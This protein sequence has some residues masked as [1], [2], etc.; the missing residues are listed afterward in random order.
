ME[1]KGLKMAL[2]KS[3]AETPIAHAAPAAAG[4]KSIW[5]DLENSPHVPFFHP[6]IGELQKD[7]RIIVTA[8]DCFQVCG[9][10]DLF[11]M[12][13]LRIGRHYGKHFLNK[14]AGLLIR[15]LQILPVA[16][17]E[18]PDL[19]V[20]HGSRSQLLVCS[21]LNIP[22]LLI[23]DYEHAIKLVNPTWLMMPEVIPA[24]SVHFDA[25][26]IIHYPGIKEDVYVPSF[27][28]DPAIM[29]ELKLSPESLIVTVRPPATEAHY[30]NPDGEKLFVDVINFLAPAKAV[31]V[32]LPRNDRQ[33][34]FVNRTWPELCARG[35]VRIPDHVVDGL[36]LIW[37]S[38]LVISGGGTINREAAA[39]GV[40]VYSIFRGRLGALDRYL[41]ETGRLVLI[42]GNSDFKKI[43]LAKRDRSADSRQGTEA[44]KKILETIRTIVNGKQ[45]QDF[46]C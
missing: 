13:Y 24:G 30:H 29:K 34:D 15:S 39:L 31:M 37:H 41:S 4:R 20:N 40:P 38:D 8:R 16:F 5:I 45:Q 12:A 3:S 35:T 42:T 46:L 9:L 6:I 22:S 25:G 43:A 10:A 33:K 23:M 7:Y 27:R 21:F 28:P 19:A 14:F 44:L 2:D 11:H 17:R 26:R 18:K 32:V 36:N 1:Q